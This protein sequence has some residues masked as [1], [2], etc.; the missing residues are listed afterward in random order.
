MTIVILQ[1]KLAGGR[2]TGCGLSG[3]LPSE[4]AAR[5]VWITRCVEDVAYSVVVDKLRACCDE[6][7]CGEEGDKGHSVKGEAHVGGAFNETELCCLRSLIEG[8]GM[9][10]DERFG[11]G[12]SNYLYL[13]RPKKTHI[14]RRMLPGKT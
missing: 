3:I 4:D 7:G 13:H 6:E 11:M 9:E 5:C 10:S 14:M 8:F 2:T 1:A 12:I